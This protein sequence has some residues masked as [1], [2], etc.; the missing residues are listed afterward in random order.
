MPLHIGGRRNDDGIGAFIAR[1]DRLTAADGGAGDLHGGAARLAGAD[2]LLVAERGLRVRLVAHPATKAG[3]A[4]GHRARRLAD[5]LLEHRQQ[6]FGIGMGEEDHPHIGT[7]GGAAIEIEH[8]FGQ[9]CHRAGI[10]AQGNRVRTVDGDD[11]HAGAGAG[12]GTALGGA[13]PAGQ[14]P[15]RGGDFTGAGILQR[16]DAHGGAV[17]VDLADQRADAGDIIGIIGDDDG[18]AAAIGGQLP[19]AADQRA[20]RLHCRGGVDRIEPDDFGDESVAP[21][22]WP[23]RLGGGT[24]DRRDAK[25]AAGRWLHDEAIG[26]QGRQEQLEIGVAG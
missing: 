6:L 19:F 1:D 14:L 16:D 13:R 5:E 26:A 18:I 8:G 11:R 9:P 12:A 23:A 20:Q 3:A 24:I 10:A 22:A 25:G 21:G 2:L 17:A 7:G 15:Q 4:A